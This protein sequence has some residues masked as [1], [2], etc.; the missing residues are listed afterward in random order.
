MLQLTKA[1]PSVALSITPIKHFFVKLI[2]EPSKTLDIFGSSLLRR[3]PYN[4]R[5]KEL[6]RLPSAQ[7]QRYGLNSISFRG[8]LLWNALHDELKTADTLRS[9]KTGIKEWDGK[10]CRCLI[11]K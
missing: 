10:G 4:L 5:T 7:S 1:L 2:T 8:S 3:I 11:C 9:F 6:C